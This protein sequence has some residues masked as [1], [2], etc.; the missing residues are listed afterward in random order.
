M[1]LLMDCLFVDLKDM[2]CNCKTFFYNSFC[3]NC[4]QEKES[5]IFRESN[6]TPS[7]LPFLVALCSNI[8]ESLATGPSGEVLEIC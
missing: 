3:C 4:Q 8:L 1:V 7:L 6:E 2:W 5:L